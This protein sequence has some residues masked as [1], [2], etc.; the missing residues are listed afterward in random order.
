MS[1]RTLLIL[2]VMAVWLPALAGFSVLA[3]VTYLREVADARQA[4]EQIGE[5]IA[6]S[7]ERE[8]DKRVFMATALAVSSALI[9]PDLRRFHREASAALKGT[10]TWALLVDE[11]TQLVN[12]VAPFDPEIRRVRPPGL[13]LLREGA[14]ILFAARGAATGRPVLGAFVPDMNSE[15]VTR[16]VGV[17]FELAEIQRI[18]DRQNYV[19]GSQAAV[20]DQDFI[21]M[22][23]SRDPQKWV[24]A[25]AGPEIQRRVQAR[26]TGFG[27]SVTLDGVHSLTYITG[28]NKYGWSIVLALPKNA[29]TAA[30]RRLT[31]QALAASAAILAIGLGGVL[32]LARRV[33]E[34]VVALRDDAMH[35]GDDSVPPERAYPVREVRE[36]SR[37]LHEAGRRSRE[38]KLLLETRVREAVVD[39]ESAQAKLL[40]GQKREAIGRLTGGL[41]HEFNNLLQTISVALQVLERDAKE[42]RNARM[43]QSARQATRRAADLVRQMLSFGRERPL[44]REAVQLAR[45]L[46]GS[47]ELTDKAVGEKIE[48]HMDVPADLPAVYVD[49][50]QL[51]LAVLNLVFNARDAMPGG[52]RID[53]T[54]ALHRA[55]P[56]VTGAVDQVCL[57][58]RDNGAGMDE[59]TKAK[60]F[61]PYFTTKPIGAGSGL[62]L[63]QVAAFVGQSEGHAAID[64]RP[65]GG[66]TV[67]LWLPVAAADAKAGAA[68]PVPAPA[69][70]GSPLNILMAEDDEL[71]CAVVVPSLERLGHAVRLCH[72]ADAAQRLLQEDGAERFDVLFTDIVMPGSLSGLD[73][74]RW[75]R[76]NRPTLPIVVATGYTV[77]EVPSDLELLR[78]PYDI[79]ALLTAMLRAIEA[80]PR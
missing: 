66:T 76:A 51:E 33:G 1:I 27:E 69:P 56:A 30:A 21:I 4:V 49:P 58:V 10:G 7:V 77:R 13:P 50:A 68:A 45:L 3:R 26:E 40:E 12:T 41:A 15:P 14:G 39:A 37:A 6:S 34:P 35:L 78:K 47:H 23:R 25:R 42:G 55:G 9:E 16:N 36:V 19:Q 72:S 54:A 62:G 80:A 63:T 79:D 28:A 31:L 5:S 73:L 70:R 53:I 65:G 24:G 43:L 52:G 48:L 38:A 32:Y 59:A 17:V 60:A 61:E 64:S 44:K 74:A 8:L 71:V 18:L 57:S 11:R 75:A 22:A 46:A 67:A 2:L 20:I 29:L